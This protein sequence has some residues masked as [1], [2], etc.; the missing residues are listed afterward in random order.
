MNLKD[1][2][3]KEIVIYGAGH[4]GRKFFRT[5]KVQGLGSQV[6]CF[7]VTK[8]TEEENVLDG[9][10]LKCIYDI[11]VQDN[12]LICLAVHETLRRELEDI[13]KG[14][15]DRYV[16]IYPYL[17][18]LMFGEPEQTDI[19][20]KISEI[21]KTCHEDF[22]LAIRLAAVEQ[23]EGKN[24][25]GYAYYKR[26]Q[27]MHCAEHTAGQRLQQFKEL[28]AD[29]KE[30]GY[31]KEYPLSL[32]RLYEVIDGNHRLAL[33]VYNRQTLIPCKIYPTEI[34]LTEIHGKEPVMPKDVLK[35]H[36]FTEKEILRLSKLQERYVDV[37][38]K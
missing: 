3:G 28:M 26:A 11:S 33:A 38:G 31:R 20:I 24:T 1:F 8:Q 35:K 30:T 23:Y 6:R 14:I 17:Y 32:N 5:L 27:M 36:G 4:V 25:F 22:R 13:V 16:W 7:A 12:T 34:P 18:S 10:P 19:E 15:T 9:I 37:Y 29:W 21:L 2:G